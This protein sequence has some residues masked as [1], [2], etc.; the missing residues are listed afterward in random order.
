MKDN[1]WVA[2]ALLA[3]GHKQRE[4]AQQWGISEAAVSRW[5]NGTENQDLPASRVYSLSRMMGIT[6]DELIERLGLAGNLPASPMRP[7]EPGTAPT[8]GT[9]QMQ[10]HSGR[11]RILLHLDVP[12]QVGAQLVTVLAGATAA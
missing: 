8:L 4:L 11:I 2:E 5:M 6:A 10:P 9:F 3:R 7:V 12:A 1:K